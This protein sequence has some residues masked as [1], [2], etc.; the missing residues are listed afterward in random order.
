M[1]QEIIKAFLMPPALNGVL[2]VAGLLLF[3]WHKKAGGVLMLLSVVCLLLLSTDYVASVFERSNQKYG[4][5][6][7]E[8]L[9][10]NEPLT[11]VVAGASHNGRT[12]EY[13]YPTPT[14]VS[15]VR[16]HYAS[17]LHRKTGYPVVLTGGE[18][19]EN[20]IHSEILA[21]S[22]QNEFKTEARWLEKKSRSTYEN[23]KYT[24]EILFPLGRKTILLVTHSY[25]MNRA[26]RSFQQVGFTVI[27]A[28]TIISRKVGMGNW[29]HWVPGASGLQRSANVIYEYFG[30][31]R[32]TFAAK[33]FPKLL[34]E[35]AG[36]KT[37][38]TC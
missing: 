16:L 37:T 29:R 36:C 26:A 22:F 19:N 2:V 34:I 14:A 38:T 32:D 13:G 21:H 33:P 1:F 17:F 31:V 23:A 27:P 35:E 11:I 18:M 30:L 8:E 9:P 4:A 15:L 25:H 3:R 6:N 12:D 28:P 24:A 10:N 20:Q 5:L 7:L